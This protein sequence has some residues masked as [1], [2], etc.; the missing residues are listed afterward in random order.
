MSL[1]EGMYAEFSWIEAL[2]NNEMQR[3]DKVQ[4]SRGAKSQKFQGSQGPLTPPPSY[5][6]AEMM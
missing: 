6:G 2:F 4:I 3:L 1:I 5:L